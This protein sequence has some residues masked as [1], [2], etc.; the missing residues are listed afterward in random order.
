MNWSDLCDLYDTSTSALSITKQAG[1]LGRYIS[2]YKN[3]TV[4]MGYAR[5]SMVILKHCPYDL[6][7]QLVEQFIKESK[8]EK[9]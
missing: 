6:M 5:M 9:N 8:N 4:Y 2:I 3:G 7:Q 1:A